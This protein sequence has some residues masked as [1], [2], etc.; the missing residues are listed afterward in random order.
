MN[1]KGGSKRALHNKRSPAS[2][3]WLKFSSWGSQMGSK[4]DRLRGLYHICWSFWVLETNLLQE[5]WC[6]GMS[7]VLNSKVLSLCVPGKAKCQ[8]ERNEGSIHPRR[9]EQDG[10]ASNCHPSPGILWR[11]RVGRICMELWREHIRLN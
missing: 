9:R 5:L 10:G 4:G 7:A 2:M 3:L 11:L 8:T 6:W 1:A